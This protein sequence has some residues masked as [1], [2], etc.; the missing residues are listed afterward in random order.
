MGDHEVTVGRPS[1]YTPEIVESIA[2]RLETGEPLAEICR[3]IGMPATRTVYDWME[4]KPDVSARIARARDVGFD[5][6]ATD[7]LRIADDARNDWIDERAQ[8]GDER[9]QVAKSNG[10]VIQRSRLRV[11][12]RLKLLAKWDPKR[13][14]EAMTLKGDKENPLSGKSEEQIRSEYAELM[15]KARV[16]T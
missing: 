2:L 6:I 12:T 13:Y 14:G 11:E 15:A 1:L 4:I 16:L 8:D 3:S 9:A 5:A 10:E 7:C